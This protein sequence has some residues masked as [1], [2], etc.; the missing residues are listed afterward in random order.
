MGR[1]QVSYARASKQ[2]CCR[3]LVLRAWQLWVWRELNQHFIANCRRWM[4]GR[5]RRT[6]G[7]RCSRWSQVLLQQQAPAALRLAGSC[8]S[9]RPSAQS[10]VACRAATCPC[11]C[12]SSACCTWPTSTACR[13]RAP[14]SWT[15]CLLCCP[16]QD[17]CGWCGSEHSHT[18]RQYVSFPTCV[19]VMPAPVGGMP[20]CRPEGTQHEHVMAVAA[21]AGG[22]Q[23]AQACPDK[24]SSSLRLVRLSGV[25]TGSLTRL[26][27][28]QPSQREV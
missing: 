23:P 12:A 28:A 6:C 26:S 13:S 9:R 5:S 10:G 24:A 7:P 18:K 17:V 22:S 2:V 25:R 8:R 20:V 11:T 19:G 27:L 16:E 21:A 14:R 1:I 4:Y 3:L 15:P